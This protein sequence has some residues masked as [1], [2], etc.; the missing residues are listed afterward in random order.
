MAAGILRA[1]IDVLNAD[2]ALAGLVPGGWWREEE[3]PAALPHG[4]VFD[5]GGTF[6]RYSEGGGVVT[7]HLHADVYAS[8]DVTADPAAPAEPAAAVEKI[9]DRAIDVLNRGVLN[10]AGANHMNLQAAYPGGTPGSKA[11][12]VEQ[13]DPAGLRIYKGTL[14][15]FAQVGRGAP[16]P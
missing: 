13:R 5:D 11:A 4:L 9:V 7:R 14:S 16:T 15:V 10:V 1:V 3:K 12:A 8:R 6:D 2:A